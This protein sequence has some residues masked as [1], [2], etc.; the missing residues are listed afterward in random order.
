MNNLPATTSIAC[1]LA[2]LCGSLACNQP[3][4]EIRVSSPH[5]PGWVQ[6]TNLATPSFTCRLENQETSGKI[7]VHITNATK[8]HLRVTVNNSVL[9]SGLDAFT[10]KSAGRVSFVGNFISFDR[11]KRMIT[12]RAGDSVIRDFE[13][14]SSSYLLEKGPRATVE[15]R[16]NRLSFTA[17]AASDTAL[18]EELNCGT[19]GVDLS[20]P[21][22]IVGSITEQLS[23]PS[24]TDG[25]QTEINGLHSM[26][27]Y[28]SSAFPIAGS[29]NYGHPD[30]V[31]FFGPYSSWRG[32]SVRLTHSDMNNWSQST[33]R[34]YQCGG[35]QSSNAVA[36]AN[37]A[38]GKIWLCPSFW[39]QSPDEK[40][41]TF[42][43]EISHITSLTEDHVY[44]RDG[45]KA[46]AITNPEQAVDNAEN[47]GYFLRDRG[48]PR[49]IGSLVAVGL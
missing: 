39:A 48:F 23:T 32:A 2:V 34:T 5:E 4:S 29:T 38:L 41:V 9:E 17:E 18:E 49:F 3:T 35:C 15:L 14:L 22:Q 45:A 26:A 47:H 11:A 12:L 6:K 36:E 19:L 46:L 30:Y 25:Q 21:S 27:R 31:S 44:T 8:Q 20:S 43:H 28:S 37:P 33:T 40:N 7:R 42:L 10:V 16:R 13:P 24:C 1:V